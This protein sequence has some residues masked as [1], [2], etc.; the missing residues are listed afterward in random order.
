MITM[1]SLVLAFSIFG[2]TNDNQA[3]NP[4]VLMEDRVNQKVEF[5]HNQALYN[6]KANTEIRDKK[7]VRKEI[8][9]QDLEKKKVEEEQDKTKG[10]FLIKF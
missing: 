3:P 2:F 6:D 4:N 8:K 10:Q 1:C 9:A 5:D 7:L